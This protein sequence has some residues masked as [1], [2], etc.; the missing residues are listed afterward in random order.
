MQQ[1]VR[2]PQRVSVH[3]HISPGAFNNIVKHLLALKDS[4]KAVMMTKKG[5]IPF[6]MADLA[7]IIL[8]FIP[9]L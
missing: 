3:Q 9:M 2:K 8:A 4:P 6:N 7:A 5:N 1:A